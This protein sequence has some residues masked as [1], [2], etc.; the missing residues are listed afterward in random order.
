[1]KI[2]PFKLE[3]NNSQFHEAGLLQLNCDKSLHYLDW[4]PNLSF[5]E[6]V[7]FTSEWYYNYYTTKE[8]I[9]DFTVSQIKDF[10]KQAISKDFIWTK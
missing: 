9:F 1:M 2:S 6:L 8:N 10:E 5:N 7:K 4:Q 3:K